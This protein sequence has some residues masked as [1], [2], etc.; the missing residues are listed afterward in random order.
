MN[1]HS[2]CVNQQCFLV[3]LLS[4]KSLFTKVA[5]IVAAVRMTSFIW[6]TIIISIRH[7]NNPTGTRRNNSIHK[8]GSRVCVHVCI[9]N[10]INHLQNV[11]RVFSFIFQ[12]WQN[13]FLYG[14]H[15]SCHFLHIFLWCNRWKCI[16]EKLL[17]HRTCFHKFT[18][19]VF[20]FYDTLNCIHLRHD[21]PY[22]WSVKSIIFHFK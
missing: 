12:K 6:R 9:Y 2:S 7:V 3:V 10:L 8:L 11:H 13:V 4:D 17:L 21:C 19:S 5:I 18:E 1:L 16:N 14:F 22:S 20:Y 15:G